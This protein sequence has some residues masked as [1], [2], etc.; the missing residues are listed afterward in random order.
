MNLLTQ[1]P[2]DNDHVAEGCEQ[3]VDQSDNR[4]LANAYAKLS[5]ALVKADNYKTLAE[6]LTVKVEELAKIFLHSQ[7][8]ECRTCYWYDG[9]GE[10]HRCRR[11]DGVCI[12]QSIHEYSAP[13]LLTSDAA[14]EQANG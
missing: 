6:Q 12:D 10:Y 11:S 4:L 8:K 9:R 5:M 2:C 13:V 3:F 14:K 7:E 1:P